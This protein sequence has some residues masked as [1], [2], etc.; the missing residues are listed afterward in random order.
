MTSR[1]PASP[2]HPRSARTNPGEWQT[3][4]DLRGG[5]H[6]STDEWARGSLPAGRAPTAR[7]PANRGN[8][9]RS[10]ADSPTLSTGGDRLGCAAEPAL[11]RKSH[12]TQPR[13]ALL[14]HA[15]TVLFRRSS[16]EPRAHSVMKERA[17]QRAHRLALA[18]MALVARSPSSA[19]LVALGSRSR[20]GPRSSLACS[21]QL[22]T[23][24]TLAGVFASLAHSLKSLH[25]HRTTSRGGRHD[26]NSR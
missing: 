25:A 26:G 19:Q 10:P 21:T 9:A 15:Q 3:S 22:I 23:V 11:T 6:E 13:P 16:G 2:Y 14:S 18:R 7:L 1:N 17:S 5:L 12:G 20:P 24:A 4:T 8:G